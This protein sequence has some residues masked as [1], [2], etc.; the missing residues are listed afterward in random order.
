MASANPPIEG[1]QV[2]RLLREQLTEMMAASQGLEGLL[3]Q[4]DTGLGYLAVLNR[5]L[6]RQLRLVQHLELNLRLNSLDEVRLALRPVDLVPLCRTLMTRVEGL[7]RFLNI[8]VR[9]TTGL[10][11]L[12]TIADSGTLET[13]LLC[14]ISNALKAVGPSSGG[15]VALEL[16]QRG[17]KA[18][19]TLRDNGK[20]MD[21]ETLAALFDSSEEEA[22]SSGLGLPLARQIAALHGGILIV[23]SQEN[24]GARLA[25]SLPVRDPDRVES[26][27]ATRP[28]LD[29]NSGLDQVLVALSDCLPI[30]AFLP[31]ELG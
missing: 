30:D 4:N 3:H 1:G 6:C 24:R 20:G 27:C 14:L 22:E 16:E 23:D 12:P 19:F 2:P 9:F 29:R 11:T 26:L 28:A 15:E 8:Q 7:A 31:E 18:V 25:V 21:A 13:M 10:T 17:D 5:S